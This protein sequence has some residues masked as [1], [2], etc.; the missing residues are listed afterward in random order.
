MARKKTNNPFPN[1]I[2][3]REPD[4][5]KLA[6]LVLKAKGEKRSISAF[7]R[8]C[9]VSTSTLSRLINME[10]TRANS[11]D[12]IA[13]IVENTDPESGVTRKEL[14]DAHGLMRIIIPGN[15]DFT[16]YGFNPVLASAYFHDL[17][18]YIKKKLDGEDTVRMLRIVTERI[19]EINANKRWGN[20][21]GIMT[22]LQLLSNSLQDMFKLESDDKKKQTNWQFYIQS[23]EETLI[24]TIHRLFG[25]IYPV[26]MSGCKSS[27]I[28]VEE[29]DF[30]LIKSLFSN[31]K[32][33]DCISIIL[34]DLDEDKVIDEFQF[35]M[36]QEWD[37][38]WM[39]K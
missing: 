36:F 20:D 34:V 15:H 29:G 14:L 22:G 9:G 17:G 26:D 13:A 23:N 3:V 6:E 16:C 37:E 33:R 38:K 19:F 27:I 4:K 7:A 32:I 1:Y 2:R 11:D 21:M 18:H 28:T 30:N 35:P 31:H 39:L 24:E 12:L 8:D 10:T 5:E 25:L